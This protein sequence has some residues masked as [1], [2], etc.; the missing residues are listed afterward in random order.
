[1]AIPLS[2]MEVTI[3]RAYQT[4]D[5]GCSLISVEGRLCEKH[6]RQPGLD[7]EVENDVERPTQFP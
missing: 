6:P 1:M 5:M 2:R 7:E 4:P 3:D